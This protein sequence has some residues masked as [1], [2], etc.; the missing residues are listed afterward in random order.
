MTSELIVVICIY[1]IT[2][3][4]VSEPPAAPSAAEKRSY[5][6]I[7]IMSVDIFLFIFNKI[8]RRAC[9]SNDVMLFCLNPS[10]RMR[11]AN[12]GFCIV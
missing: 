3:V 7:Y 12:G 2:K 5:S 8:K 11:I 10:T 9:R 4:F 6:L 1:L